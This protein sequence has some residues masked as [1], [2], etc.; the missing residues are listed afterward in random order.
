MNNSTPFYMKQNITIFVV[1]MMMAFALPQRVSAF[2][3]SAV[4]PS[5]QTLYYNIINGKAQVTYP[6]SSTGEWSGYTMPT[7]TLIIP[8]IVTHNGTNYAVTSIRRYT[9]YHCTGLN[10]VT[11][12]DSISTIGEDAFY[13]CSG[14]STITIGESVVSIDNNAFFGCNSLTRVN[15]SGSIAQWCNISFNNSNYDGFYSNPIYYSHN[16]YID[17]SLLTDLTIPN[18]VTEIKHHAFYGCSSISSLTIPNSTITIGEAAFAGCNGMTSATIGNSIT[19][20]GRDAFGGCTALVRVNYSGTISQWCNIDFLYYSFEN[21]EYPSANPLYHAHYLYIN[22]SLVQ[23]LT[24]PEDVTTIKPYSFVGCYG[25]TSLTYCSSITSI[26]QYAFSHCNNLTIVN[27]DGSISYISVGAFNDCGNL[28]NVTIPP[29]TTHILQYAFCGCT[30]I[31]SITI[32]ASITY[33]GNYAF[34]NCTSLETVN[35]MPTTAPSIDYYS[36]VNNPPDRVFNIPCGSGFSYVNTWYTYG[37]NYASSLREPI[38]D[39]SF[40]VESIDSTKGTAQVIQQ[41]GYDIAC[42]DSSIII[43][44]D[45]NYG[46][47]FDHWSNGR[48]S[49]PDTLFL[50]GDSSVTAFFSPN[51]YT[52][53]VLSAN[54]ELGSVSEGGTFNYLDTVLIEATVT[55]DHYHFVRWSDNNTDNP[56]QYVIT[57]DATLRA[58]FSIDRFI[59]TAVPNNSERGSVNGGHEY[60]YGAVCTLTA[61][62]FSGYQFAKWSD[63][64]TSNPYIFAVSEDVDLRALF[65]T[66]GEQIYSINATSA[67]PTMGKVY[68]GGYAVNGDEVTLR[69]VSYP[70][71]YFSHWSDNE[72][73]STRTIE[74]HGNMTLTAHFAPNVGIADIITNNIRIFSR[75]RQII[76]EGSEGMRIWV[77][78][79]MGRI[80]YNGKTPIIPIQQTGVYIVKV[81]NN[82][83]RKVVVMR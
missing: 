54:E 1:F 80:I 37:Y 46:Y 17:D 60:S 44:A 12:G 16:L 8:S 81:G 19:S 9:F 35:M 53:T 21:N 77:F 28:T 79:M 6:C 52:L 23:N 20:I 13:G 64:A 50:S 66:E 30:S 63:G 22:D 11:I 58:Y 10:M 73:D 38:V 48:T 15:F 36:F 83:P 78:D 14:L 70:G 39:I 47:H 67:D 56:R 4:A 71:Y 18:G 72:T 33:I 51:Q 69:A 61:G 40:N 24:I 45:S 32:P 74:V 27:I 29:A 55:A 2:N 75:D 3:F 31:S 41:N 25:L 5:G 62:A 26:G 42:I 82:P 68:G 65:V 76:V 59:V 43:R 7:G 57:G 34:Y 49:N